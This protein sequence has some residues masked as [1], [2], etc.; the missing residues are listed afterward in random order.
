M[1]RT[2]VGTHQLRQS[3]VKELICPSR[4]LLLTCQTL[5]LLRF[6]EQ[7]TPPDIE[8]QH[9]IAFW[10]HVDFQHRNAAAAIGSNALL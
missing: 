5:W 10:G 3:V 6:A 8:G 4:F 9:L 2:D 1:R 7:K